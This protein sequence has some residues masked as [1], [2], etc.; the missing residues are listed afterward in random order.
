MGNYHDMKLRVLK[1]F[2][3][4]HH[5]KILRLRGAIY[6]EPNQKRATAL[7]QNDFV[8]M[9]DPPI[10][11]PTGNPTVE[12]KAAKPRKPRKKPSAK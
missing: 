3:D 6:E 10:E 11:Q 2:Y 1:D 8:Q 4:A 7:A 12:T 5:N 9:I